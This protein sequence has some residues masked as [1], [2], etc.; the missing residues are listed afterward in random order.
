LPPVSCSTTSVGGLRG[1]IIVEAPS[2][3]FPSPD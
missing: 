1:I 3:Y 2:F